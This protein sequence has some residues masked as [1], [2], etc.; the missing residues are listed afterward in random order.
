MKARTDYLI[1]IAVMGLPHISNFDDFD[2]LE[3]EPGVRLRYVEAGDPLG[4][5]DM[6]II[7]ATKSTVA[8][9]AW[10]R[11]TGLAD[12]LVSLSRTGISVIRICGGYQM[13]G[14]RILDPQGVETP[15]REM[16]GLQLLPMTT[17]F[18]RTKETHRVT[19]EVGS[20]PGLLAEASG[21]P[22]EG[23]EIHMGNSFPSDGETGAQHGAPIRINERSG[24]FWD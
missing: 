22:V 15:Q 12:D 8:D 7:P 9:L 23:Y 11:A 21:L 1:D 14:E 17:V 16:A 5:P 3:R 19:G 4:T 2:T 18:G 13:L 10:L 6:V 20:V 24:Q